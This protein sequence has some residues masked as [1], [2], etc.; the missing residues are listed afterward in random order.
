MLSDIISNVKEDKLL[1]S[2]DTHK[3][4][5]RVRTK[6]LLEILKV[7]GYDEFRA[8]HNYI[9]FTKKSPIN[10]ALIRLAI[11]KE[12]IQKY[13]QIEILAIEV[14]PRAYMEKLPQEYEV[15]FNRY[16]HLKSN[17]TL[18]IKTLDRKKIFFNYSIKAKVNITRARDEIKKGDEIS[19]LNSENDSIML[20]KFRAMPL[21]N[22]KKSTFEAKHK[23]KKNSIITSRDVTGLFLI[24]RGSRVS[25]TVIDANIAVSFGARANQN[26][27]L[28]DTITLT[29]SYKK[30]I[31]ATVVGR[32]KAEIR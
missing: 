32:N 12:Y 25:V 18:Y 11:K 8:K 27:R 30:K 17:S 10:T 5:K 21:S 16:A 15:V 22:I 3:H 20:D 26:G 4:T 6:E 2:I 28:G 1:F 31:K 7:L 14:T 13:K 9:Q 19:N 23:L 29:N 24:K